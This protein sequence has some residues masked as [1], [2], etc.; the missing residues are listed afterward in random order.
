MQRN[1]LFAFMATMLI[2]LLGFVSD[3]WPQEKAEDW[4]V[5]GNILSRQ[6]RFKEAI[7]AYRRSVEN[8]PKAT[9]AFFN[10]G[11]AYKKLNRLE[12]AR[13]MVRRMKSIH[14]DASVQAVRRAV[15]FADPAADEHYMIGLRLAGLIED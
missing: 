4:F 11:L 10:L 9:V 8:N 15:P 13:D 6:S 7:E 14:P 12:E 2:V 5:K 3:T 1:S